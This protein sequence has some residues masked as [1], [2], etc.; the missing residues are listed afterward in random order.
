[1]IRT[2]T[3]DVA[4][5]VA[6]ARAGREVVACSAGPDLP[7]TVGGLGMTWDLTTTAP[8]SAVLPDL[9]AAADAVPLIPVAAQH[10]PFAGRRIKRTLL[11]RVRPGTPDGVRARFEADLTAMPAHI[12]AIRSWALSRVDTARQPATPWTHVWEQ[13][14]TDPDGLNGE[15]LLH[16]YHWTHVDRWFDAEIPSAIVEPAIAHLFRW[17]DGP[18]LH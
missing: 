16:P 18:V 7:G 8:P 13:E 12:T 2:P 11:L 1:M 6:T 15:Y 3:T 4:P 9:S 10:V 17:A 14:F 5:A